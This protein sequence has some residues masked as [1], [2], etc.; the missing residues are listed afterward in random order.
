[1]T[2]ARIFNAAYLNFMLTGNIKLILSGHQQRS[3]A[4]ANRNLYKGASIER[5]TDGSYSLYFAGNAYATRGD[6]RSMVDAMA[7]LDRWS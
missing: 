1:M 7:Y 2:T 5:E 4:M 6:F 3:T